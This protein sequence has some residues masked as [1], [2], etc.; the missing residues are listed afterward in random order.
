M[1]DNPAPK[2]PAG[3]LVDLAFFAPL[4]LA[5]T[6]GDAIP[7]L[8]RKGRSRLAPQLGTARMVGQLA[9]GEGRQ[10]L[11]GMFPGGVPDLFKAGSFWG[12]SLSGFPLGPFGPP[13]ARGTAAPGGAAQGAEPATPGA[14]RPIRP[15]VRRAPDVETASGHRSGA[16]RAQ[17][18]AIPSYD[19]LSASQVVQRLAGLSV[20]EVRAVRAYEASTRGRR[21]ILTKADQLLS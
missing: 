18:L 17:A 16:G 21:T 13:A 19:S 12:R 4:G 5:M 11:A 3:S 9:V 2:S 8:A 14:E 15:V 6:L 20:D 7:E 1:A 10:R